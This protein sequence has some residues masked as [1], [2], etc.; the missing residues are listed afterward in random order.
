M[1]KLLHP[2]AR[3]EAEAQNDNTQDARREQE[4]AKKAVEQAG[5]ERLN[6]KGLDIK[7]SPQD[8]QQVKEKGITFNVVGKGMSPNIQVL[9]RNGN[10]LGEPVSSIDQDKGKKIMSIVNQT[11]NPTTTPDASVPASQERADNNVISG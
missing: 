10:T 9:D 3:R 4:A 2:N 1:T 5:Y 11:Q 7:V 8:M 6:I